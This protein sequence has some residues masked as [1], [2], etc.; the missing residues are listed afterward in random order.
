MLHGLSLIAVQWLLLLWGISSRVC[1]LQKFWLTGLVAPWHVGSSLT[2]DETRVPCI[3]RQILT[4]GLAGKPV[5]YFYVT[6]SSAH[7]RGET[8]AQKADKMY[9]RCPSS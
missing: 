7:M 1:G 6:L 2:K 5:T 3:A 9:A 8:E 4:I